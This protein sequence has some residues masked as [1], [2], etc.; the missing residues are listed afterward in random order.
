MLAVGLVVWYVLQRTPTGRRLYATGGNVSAARLAG[1]RTVARDRAL[2]G[3]LRRDR[4][5]GRAADERPARGRRPDRRPGLP[6]ARLRRRLPGL[7]PVPRRPVQRLG[8]ASSPSSSSRSGSRASSSPARRCGSPTSSTASR[9]CSPSAMSKYQRTARRSAAV[10]R[11]LRR[12]RAR[13]ELPRRPSRRSC[14]EE[15]LAVLHRMLKTAA[16]GLAGR[17]GRARG[18][19]RRRERQRAPR[20]PAA[21]TSPPPGRRRRVHGQADRLPGRRAAQDQAGGQDVRLP[22]VLDAGVRAVRADRGADAEAARLQAQGRQGRRVGQ[23]GAERDGLDR[24]RSSR[25][26]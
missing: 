8:H 16:A 12:E 20:R 17:G 25:P 21:R 14:A 15:E 1:V 19:R 13:S 23:R 7:H 3:E 9:C 18:M 26:A 24:R 22:P 10:A 4:G 2:A 11:I 6:A 5:A